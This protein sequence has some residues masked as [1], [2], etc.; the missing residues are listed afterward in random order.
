MGYEFAERDL[1]HIH[2]V[3]N[4]LEHSAG[5]ASTSHAGKVISLDYWRARIWAVLAMPHLPMHLEKQS[6]KLL[7][8]LDQLDRVSPS[9]TAK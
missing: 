9:T 4:H 3:L 6:K 8:R 5:T 1:A 7:A 2:D